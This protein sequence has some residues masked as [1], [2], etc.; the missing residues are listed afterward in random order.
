MSSINSKR[1]GWASRVDQPDRGMCLTELISF[2]AIS[3]IVLCMALVVTFSMA[4]HNG[5]N[6]AR[7]ERTDGTRQVSLWLSD[8]LAHTVPDPSGS[9]GS[10]FQTATERKMAFTS[11]LPAVGTDQGTVARVTLVVDEECWSGDADPGVLHRCVQRSS[12]AAGGP[13]GFCLKGS[14]GC[15]D[16]LFEDFMVAKNVKAGAVFRYSVQS[17]SGVSITSEVTNAVQLTQIVAVELN[18]TVGGVPGSGEEDVEATVV[19]HHIVNGWSRL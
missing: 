19:K 4:K 17:A 14:S 11:A 16:D 18:V 13:A 9:N 2:V 3:S 15:S 12:T 5:K 10:V 6:L 8:A 7:Q 1:D